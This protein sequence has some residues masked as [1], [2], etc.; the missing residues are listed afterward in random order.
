MKK[1]ILI[2]DD[3]PHIREVISF[4]LEQEEMEV[5]DASNGV[6]ALE[7]LQQHSP[8]LVILDVMMPE[9]D[10]LDVCREIRKSSNVAIL[11]LSARNE[12]ID[13]VIGLELGGDDYVAKPF[14]PRELVARV[15]AI[16]RRID[17]ERQVSTE[18]E[19]QP[20]ILSIGN[21]ALHTES[22]QAYWQKRIVHLTAKEFSL[23]KTLV[24]HPNKVFER[25]ELMDKT[26]SR[27]IV[28][29]DRTIDS[30]IR[31]IRTKFSKAG[32]K[33]VITTVHSI[34]YKIGRCL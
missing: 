33:E 26:Y 14:S 23:L 16:F 11:F 17:A 7:Q 22:Y 13:R 31:G 4:A 24:S 19:S 15:K 29:S 18:T 21:L 34:G 28:V 25:D 30:H 12:E 27:D 20:P 1:S 10:G 3:D 8:D 6:E 2:V 5:L 32:C 9:M